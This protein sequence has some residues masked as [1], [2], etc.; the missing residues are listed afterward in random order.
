MTN[1]SFTPTQQRI[2]E[3]LGDGMPHSRSELMKCIDDPLSDYT[4]LNNQLS[5]I[6]RKIRPK[7]REIVCETVH[8]QTHYRLVGLVGSAAE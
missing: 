4:C 2:L 7:A 5:K 3:V 8:R 6:R 1:N